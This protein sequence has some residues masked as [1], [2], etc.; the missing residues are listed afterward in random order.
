MSTHHRPIVLPPNQPV[1]RP[2]RGGRGIAEFR[3]TPP[4]G[5]FAPEDF[6]ASTTE[7]FSSDGVG[8]TWLDGGVTLAASIAEDPVGY[9]GPEHVHQ[10][11]ADPRLLVKLLDTEERLFVHFH[12]G[13]DFARQCLGRAHGKTEAWHILS[14]HGEAVVWLGFR[15]NVDVAELDEWYRSQHAEE[16]LAAM[17]RL[18]VQPGDTVVVPA[19]MPHAIGA[20]ITLVELQQP[21]DLSIVLEYRGY[22]GLTAD[23]ATLGLASTVAWTALDRN[24]WS[25]EQL[26]GLVRSDSVH[27]ETE[28]GSVLPIQGHTYFR[29]DRIH[30]NGVRRLAACYEVL[31]VIDGVGAIT[32]DAGTLPVRKGQTILLPYGVGPRELS[33][34]VT[35]LRCRPPKPREESVTFEPDELTAR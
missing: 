15:R 32:S 9:L 26:A 35:V 28:H 33:G 21:E 3:G 24:A 10:Y 27:G 17:H 1:D 12:P 18:V 2:Y 20:G 6:V 23:Q 7:V 11:G 19:G 13:D 4:A 30:V 25:D 16:M 31:V 14:V 29:L 5:E 22:R 34:R 8:L